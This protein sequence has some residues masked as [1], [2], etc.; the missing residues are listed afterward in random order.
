MCK[1][2]QKDAFLSF[3]KEIQHGARQRLLNK[4]ICFLQ[5]LT[6][7]CRPL[8]NLSLGCYADWLHA[9]SPWICMM[10]STKPKRTGSP[11]SQSGWFTRVSMVVTTGFG[12]ATQ[13]SF[14]SIASLHQAIFLPNKLTATVKE[15]PHS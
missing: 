6:T 15:L 3:L 4:L 1:S 14:I 2:L 7:Q 11:T 5:R 9:G 12:T 10:F 13:V 8:A